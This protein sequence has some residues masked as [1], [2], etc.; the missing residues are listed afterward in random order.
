MS[1]NAI[2]IYETPDKKARFYFSHSDKNVTTGVLVMEPGKALVKHN[3]PCAIENLTQVYGKCLM[4]L[5]DDDNKTKEYE[6]V[7]GEGVKMPK[8]Q[9]HIHA[10][11]YDEISITIFKADGD[12]VDIVKHIIETNNFIQTNKPKNLQKFFG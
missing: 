11:P 3:R 7:I 10:N 9:W 2:T 1:D 12:I 5:F 8:G 4:T 6:L